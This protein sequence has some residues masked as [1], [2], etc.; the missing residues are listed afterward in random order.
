M[1]RGLLLLVVALVTVAAGCKRDQSGPPQQGPPEVKVSKP[2]T[3]RNVI[4][5]EYFTGHTEAYKRVEVRSHVTGYLEEIKFKDGDIVTEG[6]VLFVIDQRTFKAQVAKAEADMR[7]AEAKLK[8]MDADYA[9][10]RVLYPR[11]GI[12]K[13]DFDLLVGNRDEAYAAV[14]S[15]RANLRLAEENLQ[16]TE[17]K[18]PIAGRISRRL[19]DIGNT[20][21]QDETMLTT[22]VTLEPIYAYFDV[23]ERTLLR[24]RIT[25][26][27]HDSASG[28]KVKVDIGLADEEG[29]PHTGTVDFVDNVV[30]TGTGT[31]WM[32]AEFDRKDGK[33]DRS[34]AP[35]LFI[36]VRFPLGAPYKPP[37]IAEQ[38]IGTDQ[39][40]KFVYVVND[41]NKVEYREVKVG[42]M[43]DGLRV[44]K[45]G[46]KPGEKVVVSGLQRVRAGIEVKP[47]VIPMQK[48]VSKDQPARKE[49]KT[50]HENTKERKRDKEKE[51]RE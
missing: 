16:Y 8:R 47:D 27:R 9:R 49:E 28:A 15:A 21:K 24:Q 29:Y 51:A 5:Y 25:D 30:D 32:R 17:I 46:L 14:G 31:M 33:A 43:E 26:Y 20:V 2:I 23:D 45:S 18:A 36:R 19:L 13:E 48:L 37:L 1:R 7:Q 40:Q 11:G 34:L 44:I 39:G 35:G 41:S 10:G 22:I 3:D 50:N 6:Q 12:S 4:D 42:R 38:A